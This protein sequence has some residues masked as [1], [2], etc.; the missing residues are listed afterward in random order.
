MKIS[1]KNLRKIILENLFQENNRGIIL[2]SAVNL[3]KAWRA[4]SKFQS[5]TSDDEARAELE[6]FRDRLQDNKSEESGPFRKSGGRAREAQ[7]LLDDIIAL[8]GANPRAAANIDLGN[9]PE[10]DAGGDETTADPG[11][12]IE[13][14]SP[15]DPKIY[16]YK[17]DGYEYRV[18]QQTGCW[19]AKKP[20]GNWFSMKQYPNNMA[21]LDTKYPDARSQELRAKCA[22]S[23]Q[24]ASSG[25][26]DEETPLAEVVLGINGT[27]IAFQNAR[28]YFGQNTK[29][30]LYEVNDLSEIGLAR[31]GFAS[32]KRYFVAYRMNSLQNP[33]QVTAAALIALTADGMT[34]HFFDKNKNLVRNATINDTFGVKEAAVSSAHRQSGDEA[35]FE[36]EGGVPVGLVRV[37]EKLAE[38][39]NQPAQQ[40]AE[41]LSRGSLLRRRYWG[42]Y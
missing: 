14:P 34:A 4:A 31:V 32:P 26:G 33:G 20:G 23:S 36:G 11:Q 41:S 12:D 30:A 21:N 5:D 25:T 9:E 38:I 7:N 29:T 17:D 18:N 39:G 15:D 13:E 35:F 2:E 22:G 8:L 28:G 37:G 40:V 27:K 42:R 19:E 1:K 10:P 3:N 16:K 6:R 24:Q